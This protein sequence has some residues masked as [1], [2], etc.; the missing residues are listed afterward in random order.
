MIHKS[1]WLNCPPERAFALFTGEISDWWPADRRHIRDSEG[2]IFLLASGRFF[3]RGGDGKEIELGKVRSWEAPSRLLLEFYVGTDAHHPTEVE[4]RFATE[5]NGTRVTVDHRQLPGC[6]EL[7]A[8]RAP[9][10]ERTWDS[11]LAALASAAPAAD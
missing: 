5:A 6:D 4:I 3:E 11:V 1:V 9:I 2:E 7:W 8:R 10:L